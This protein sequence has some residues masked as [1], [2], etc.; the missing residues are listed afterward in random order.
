[1]DVVVGIWMW[2]VTLD[3]TELT[4]LRKARIYVLAFPL[5]DGCDARKSRQALRR[6]TPSL[7]AG[8]GRH[9]F[10]FLTAP[11]RTLRLEVIMLL[12]FTISY[13]SVCC[14]FHSFER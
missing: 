5:R 14:C 13:P 12:L 4:Q 8:V 6:Q 7:E 3:S 9:G 10:V 1:M 2:L 11:T